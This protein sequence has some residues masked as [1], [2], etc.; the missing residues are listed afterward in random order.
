MTAILASQSLA[1]G[2]TATSASTAWAN[3]DVLVCTCTN[4]AA[5][6]NVGARVTLSGSIDG[7]HFSALDSRTFGGE[8]NQTY[9]ESFR[10]SDYL[11]CGANPTV[12]LQLNSAT[13]AS[14][15]N[16]QL[17]FAGGD[18]QAVTVSAAH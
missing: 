12:L 8:A 17:T 4:G 6:P 18:T 13:G 7:T 15:S 16:L 9:Y 2:A 3:N 5:P 10:L 11:G 1:A 14:Y